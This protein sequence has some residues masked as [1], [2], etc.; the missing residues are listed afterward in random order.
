MR[1]PH[2]RVFALCGRG[3]GHS[4]ALSRAATHFDGDACWSPLIC[5]ACGLVC[6]DGARDT[7]TVRRGFFSVFCC[8]CGVVC[9]SQLPSFC[10]AFACSGR[11]MG[12]RK[13]HTGAIARQRWRIGDAEPER[14]WHQRAQMD[15]GCSRCALS[16]S[17]P[18]TPFPVKSSTFPYQ[19]FRFAK[20]PYQK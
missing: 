16:L 17:L 6:G 14:E 19:I 9:V 18:K 13:R 10:G 4:G 5:G 15:K 20:F 8:F 3:C 7:G 1:V 2:G 11:R 12:G